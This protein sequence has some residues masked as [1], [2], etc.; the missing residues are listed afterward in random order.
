MHSKTTY[1]LFHS[2]PD[3]LIRHVC[4]FDSTYHDVFSTD[5]FKKE[6]W[7]EVWKR[8][9]VR[10]SCEYFVRS[11]MRKILKS[12][13]TW[14]SDWGEVYIRH[15]K[16]FHAKTWEELDFETETYFIWSTYSKFLRWKLMPMQRQTPGKELQ[17]KK[18]KWK[19]TLEPNMEIMYDGFCGTMQAIPFTVKDLQEMFWSK[20]CTPGTVSL[21]PLKEEKYLLDMN[22]MVD[23]IWM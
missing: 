4:E 8:P 2:L 20:G 22:V 23:H 17:G 10:E 14:K 1:N 11:K 5:I 15:G 16:C 7:E 12:F 19:K 21:Y 18:A 13:R 6:L 3:D 9:F